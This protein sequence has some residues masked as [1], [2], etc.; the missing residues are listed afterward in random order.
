MKDLP[1]PML[2]DAGL[3][4]GLIPSIAQI[5]ADC[6]ICDGTL[7]TFLPDPTT[8][9]M[10]MEALEA[11]WRKTAA[12][13]ASDQREIVLQFAYKTNDG[14]ELE[15][16]GYASLFMPFAETGPFRSHVEKLMVSPKHRRKGIARVVMRRI[17]ELA[18]ERNRGLI[19]SLIFVCYASMLRCQ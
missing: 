9:Q 14:D 19:V 10:N 18:E 17:E 15:L 13:A 7:A 4:A 2:F 1:A 5:H 6:V 3:H 8:G 16:A 11:F 12:E